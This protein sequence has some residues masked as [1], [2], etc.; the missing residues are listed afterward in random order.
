MKNFFIVLLALFPWLVN[1]QDIPTKPNPARFVNDYV[2]ILSADQNADLEHKLKTFDD[3]TSNQVVVVIVATTNGYDP[4][5]YA[6]S[7]GRKWGVGTKEFNNGIVLLI[8]KDDRKVF[9]ATGYGLEG[10]LPDATC[11]EIVDNDIY[12]LF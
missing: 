1:A 10:A 6:F 2:H 12:S 9:I 4:S 5:Q 8:A 3:S 11:K 7:L